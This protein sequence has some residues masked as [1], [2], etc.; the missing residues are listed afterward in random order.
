MIKVILTVLHTS[1]VSS[2]PKRHSIS[3]VLWLRS[4][5]GSQNTMWALFHKPIPIQIAHPIAVAYNSIPYF[6]IE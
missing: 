1:T 4:I 5:S 2:V 3:S 6:A